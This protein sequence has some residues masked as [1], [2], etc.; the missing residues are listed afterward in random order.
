M[1]SSYKRGAADS[2]L[3]G[4]VSIEHAV[5]FCCLIMEDKPFESSPSETVA[6]ESNT[7]HKPRLKKPVKPGVEEHKAAIEQ[8][9]QEMQ[10][11]RTRLDEIKSLIDQKRQAGG[12]PEVLKA[13]GKL[14]DLSSRFK[15]ELVSSRYNRLYQPTV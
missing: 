7:A 4:R 8:L 1:Q 11:R 15:A 6:P 9:Q 13:R 3:Q 12:G 14:N 2:S 10:K 5:A